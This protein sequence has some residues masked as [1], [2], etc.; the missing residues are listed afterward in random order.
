M[1]Y[2]DYLKYFEETL[3]NY[4]EAVRNYFNEPCEFLSPN[5]LLYDFTIT[6]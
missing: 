3:I 5:G 2:S 6:K 4:Y 1:L